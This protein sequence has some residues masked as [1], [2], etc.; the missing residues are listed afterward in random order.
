MGVAAAAEINQ[1][2]RSPYAVLD[3]LERQSASFSA[4][5]CAGQA[6]E[7][8]LGLDMGLD[9]AAIVS[10]LLTQNGSTTWHSTRDVEDLIGYSS[11]STVSSAADTKLDGLNLLLGLSYAVDTPLYTKLDTWLRNHSHLALADWDTA[12]LTSAAGMVDGLATAFE[13]FQ[14]KSLGIPNTVITASDLRPLIDGLQ[15]LGVATVTQLAAFTHSSADTSS[16]TLVV[17]RLDAVVDLV[18]DIKAKAYP[19]AVGEVLSF[20]RSFIIENTSQAA[21]DP[22][23]AFLESTGP[24]IAQVAAAKTSAEVEVALQNFALP[25]GS[26]VRVQQEHFSVTLN[27]YFGVTAGAET[28]LGG[29]EGTGAARTRAHL[30]FT[31]PVGLGFNWGKVQNSGKSTASDT[32]LFQTGSWS[33]FAPILDVGAVASWRLGSGGGQVPPIT[34]AN[35]VAP[36]LYV[37]WTRKN[38]PFS[39]MFGAQY[40]P[41]LTKISTGGGATIERAALQFPSIQFTFDI[42]VLFLYQNPKW[43][44]SK[45]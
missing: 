30:G 12:T 38:T 7:V 45:P 8:I 23:Y 41:E 31:A 17:Q 42:P 35:I 19:A 36:G 1:H 13:G 6:C 18:A 27:S 25:A 22:V 34:W 20:V 39:I 44:S 5:N 15:S 40:G 2:G 37:V 14:T 29:L 24:F 3:G 4:P 10:H 32:R 33:L 9:V 28:L 21:Q 11:L 16:V 26:Y 43:P